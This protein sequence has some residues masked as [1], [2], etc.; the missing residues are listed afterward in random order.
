[1]VENRSGGDPNEVLRT[2]ILSPKQEEE[3]ANFYEG[4][5]DGILRFH[6]RVLRD[7]DVAEDLTQETFLRAMVHWGALISE[8]KRRSWLYSIAFNAFIDFRRKQIHARNLGAENN[9]TLT[10]AQPFPSPEEV[11][12][13]NESRSDWVRA[14]NALP[15]AQ[16]I[17]VAL[18]YFGD[19][20]G[21]EIAERTNMSHVAV[22][23]AVHRGIKKLRSSPPP[24]INQF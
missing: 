24:D 2:P 13:Q 22:R 3:F 12:I 21:A 17:A 11:I 10:A 14:I 19:A 20:S 8:E 1:M 23:V 6:T 4:Y 9:Q 15:Q 16:R 7:P 5:R 18:R